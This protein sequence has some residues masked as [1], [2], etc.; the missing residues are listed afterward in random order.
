MCVDV[1]RCVSVCQGAHEGFDNSRQIQLEGHFCR[2]DCLSKIRK[3]RIGKD[4]KGSE[5]RI[6]EHEIQNVSLEKDI[7]FAESLFAFF[8]ALFTNHH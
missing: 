1:C 7:Q 2:A 5:P 8:L 3:E 6:Q 4:Q